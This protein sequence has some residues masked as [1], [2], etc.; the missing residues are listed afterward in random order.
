MWAHAQLSPG[1]ALSLIVLSPAGG[2][3]ASIHPSTVLPPGLSLSSFSPERTQML[4]LAIAASAALLLKEAEA[5]GEE[6]E[7]SS[8]S[9]GEEG[10]SWIG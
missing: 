8:E 10:S 9:V 5:E 7:Q 1:A 2:D 3:A 6:E 4:E